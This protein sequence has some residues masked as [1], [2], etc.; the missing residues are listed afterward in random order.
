MFWPFKLSFVVDILAYFELETVWATFEKL[1][2]FSN[3]QVTLLDSQLMLCLT[4][5][6]PCLNSLVSRDWLVQQI[7]PLSVCPCKKSQCAL[8][9]KSCWKLTAIV[10]DLQGSLGKHLRPHPIH[11]LKINV[12]I[13]ISYKILLINLQ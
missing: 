3:L 12:I 11:F 13:L 10:G 4:S 6:S 9:T 8:T 1:G 5:A 7:R 2:I